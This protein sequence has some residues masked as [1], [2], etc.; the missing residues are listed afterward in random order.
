MEWTEDHDHSLCQEILALE[1]FKARKGS[2]ARGQ[3]WDQIA[4]NLNSLEIPS[5]KVNKRPVRERHSLLIEK[6]KKKLAEE[7][8]ASGIETDMNDVEKALEEILEKEADAENTLATGKKR[9]DNAKAVEMRNRAMESMRTTQKRNQGDEDKDAENAHKPKKT[10][11]SGGDTLTYL[12][13]KNDMV[14]KWKAEEMELHKQRL[15]VESRK[16]DEFQKQ[17]QAMMQMM[18]Q[19]QQQF[20]MFATMQQQQTQVILKLLEKQTNK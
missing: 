12:R 15:E 11:R 6:L 3:I 17:Q 20:Q 1:P 16:Q 19:Q 18:A 9:V 13:E 5:F 2:I 7:E 10:R 4:S 8:K 14:Q